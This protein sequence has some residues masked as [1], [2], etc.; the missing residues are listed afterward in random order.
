MPRQQILDVNA[1]GTFYACR[2]AIPGMDRRGY[3]RV[4]LV[5]LIAGREG[6]PLL[7]AYAAAK[8]AV[9]ALA[10]SIGRDVVGSGVLVNVVTPA[11]IETPMTLAQPPEM[12]ERM[13]ASVPLGRF[14]TPAEASRLIAWLASEDCSFSTGA[15]YD[16]S[17]G[18]GVI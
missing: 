14:G 5:S 10:K 15:V 2:A 13:L 1:T 7:P 3:G 17:S 12:I 18:R 16:L 4:V 9:I 6:S 8:A 11:V